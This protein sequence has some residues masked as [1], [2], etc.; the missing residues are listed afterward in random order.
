MVYNDY[1]ET[2]INKSKGD[3]EGETNEVIKPRLI[4]ALASKG[5]E[6]VIRTKHDLD[7]TDLEETYPAIYKR[8][9]AYINSGCTIFAEKKIYTTAFQIAG[10]IDVLVVKGRQFAILDWKTNKDEMMFRS[11]YF[12]KVEIGGKWI[13]GSEFILMPKYLFAPLN[14]LEDCK[15]II[16]TLQLSL[17]AFIMELWG[18]TLVPNGL[19]IFHI[20][21][22]QEPKL[23]KVKYLKNDVHNM[24]VHHLENNKPIKKTNI[25]FGIR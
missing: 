11:G 6:V 21:P 23:I 13:K 15:G 2:S 8:L 18:Y 20:R 25:K 4:T 24:L 14:N 12:K 9:L 10:M 5:L 17:Y 16:Y 1:L 7:L 19:E 22:N 3:E